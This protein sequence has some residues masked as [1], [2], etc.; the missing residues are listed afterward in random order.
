L[1]APGRGVVVLTRVM[2]A[3]GRE[4]AE[5]RLRVALASGQQPAWAHLG[6]I[7]TCLEALLARVT[8]LRR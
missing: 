8:R 1:D 3:D 7:V 2:A 6:L 4:H 5:I